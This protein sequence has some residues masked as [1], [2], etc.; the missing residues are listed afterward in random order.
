[1]RYFSVSDHNMAASARFSNVCF[2]LSIQPVR[3]G[4]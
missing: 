4:S 2:W 3:R 1:M